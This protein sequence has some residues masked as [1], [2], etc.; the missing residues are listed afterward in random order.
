M[1]TTIHRLLALAGL[2]VIGAVS[3]AQAERVTVTGRIS[4][5]CAPAP[6]EF[7]VAEG[8][9]AVNFRLDG[10][11]AGQTCTTHQP[12]EQKGFSI[13]DQNSN[14]VYRYRGDASLSGLSLPAGRYR[15]SVDGGIGAAVTLTFD[16]Q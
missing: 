9:V 3:S 5:S 14:P 13:L 12:I 6:G 1:N 8:A 4:D 11:S 7:V 2:V 15:L 16:V 10:L